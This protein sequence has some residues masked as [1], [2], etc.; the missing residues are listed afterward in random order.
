MINCGIFLN[1]NCYEICKKAARIHSQ[2][3]AVTADV[4]RSKKNN[5]G[6]NNGYV[7]VDRGKSLE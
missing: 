1:R 2:S 5:T 4:D 7:P 3:F 6:E